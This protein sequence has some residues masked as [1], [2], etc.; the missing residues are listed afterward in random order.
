MGAPF[1]PARSVPVIMETSKLRKAHE[2][3]QGRLLVSP[4]SPRRR[5]LRQ[6]TEYQCTRKC[7]GNMV[8]YSLA[9]FQHRAVMGINNK[10]FQVEAVAYL[11]SL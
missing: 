4:N 10:R 5:E 1:Y 6:E 8:H 3:N 11:M 7:Y 9:G 2:H